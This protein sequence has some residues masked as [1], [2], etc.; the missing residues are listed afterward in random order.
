MYH[1]FLQKLKIYKMLENKDKSKTEISELG[2]FGLI[3]HLTKQFSI[4]QKSTI[5]GIGDDAAVIESKQQLVIYYRSL[6]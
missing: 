3:D 2:E 4:K 5:K 6:N 1:V